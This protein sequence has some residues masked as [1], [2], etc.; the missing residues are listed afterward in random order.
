MRYFDKDTGEE[1]DTYTSEHS[2][3]Y[4]LIGMTIVLPLIVIAIGLILETLFGGW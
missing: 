3:L 1:K 4:N 2:F